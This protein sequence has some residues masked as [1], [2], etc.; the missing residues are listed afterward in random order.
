[1]R[2][3]DAP[4]RSNPNPEEEKSRVGSTLSIAA[5]YF[6]YTMF[7]PHL[8]RASISDAPSVAPKMSERPSLRRAQTAPSKVITGPNRT[9]PNWML[10]FSY[11]LIYLELG[12]LI[13]VIWR[14]LA[15]PL[16]GVAA[17]AG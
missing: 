7:Q 10:A 1:M 16:N 14:S 2:T 12:W 5:P 17:Q 9:K 4:S 6:E 13:M 8:K 15:K 11:M 3:V